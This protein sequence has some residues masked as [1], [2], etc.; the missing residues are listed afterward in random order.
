MNS[1]LDPAKGIMVGLGMAIGFYL[2]VGVGVFAVYW[3]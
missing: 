2:I 3:L 1:D